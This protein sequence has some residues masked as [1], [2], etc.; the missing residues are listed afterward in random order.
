MRRREFI[1]LIGSAITWPFSAWAQQAALPLVGFLSSTSEQGYRPFIDAV[2]RGLNEQGFSQGRNITVEYRWADGKYEV[3]PKFANDLVHIPARVIVAIAPPAAA[4]AKAATSTI[5]IVFSSA[6]D[7]VA[8]GLVESM[9]R[10]GGNL[11]GIN[12]L[13]FAMASKRIELLVRLTPTTSTIA[14]LANAN[15]PS[16]KHSITEAESAANELN[17]KLLVFNAGSENE[18]DAAFNQMPQQGTEALAVE[19]DP[20]LLANREKIVALAAEH[21]LPTIYPHREFA[22]AGGLISYGTSVSA[23][24]RE[25]GLYAGRILNGEKASDLPIV[26]SAHFELVINNRT[27]KSLGIAVPPNVLALADEV[28][29]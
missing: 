11:T 3:L 4:A 26:Q 24:Y 15:N 8:L 7:P 16:A 10:P 21:G 13:L 23:A 5:P 17:K 28:I 1:T 20:F 6:A 29:E 14:L 18:I 22:D 19:P 27:A 25:I 12:L 9:N 2:F